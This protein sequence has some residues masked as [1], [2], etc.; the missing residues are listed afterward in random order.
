[1]RGEALASLLEAE[2]RQR[3]QA[4]WMA[5][6]EEEV[7]SHRVGPPI[8]FLVGGTLVT[9]TGVALIATNVDSVAIATPIV[10]VGGLLL[11]TGIVT[12]TRVVR[13]RRAIR[14]EMW[15]RGRSSS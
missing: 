6:R 3:K 1:M 5:A 11:A 9:A 12:L 10:V 14:H 15:L 2:T 4:A 13:K 8:G 7:H